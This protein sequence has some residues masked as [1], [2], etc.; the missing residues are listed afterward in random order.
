MRGK[1]PYVR[2]PGFVAEERAVGADHPDRMRDEQRQRRR[3][4]SAR[5]LADAEVLGEEQVAD[6][7]ERV[8]TGLGH[9][10]GHGP[11]LPAEVLRATEG[12]EPNV[13]P[14]RLARVGGASRRELGPDPVACRPV[15]ETRLERAGSAG[16]DPLRELDQEPRRG[17]LGRVGVEGD[18]EALGARVIDQR[19]HRLG[20][21]G[22][23]LAMVEVGDVGRA[24]ARRPISIASRNGSR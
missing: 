5:H 15:R 23:R 6:D 10:V 16:L 9:D 14:A 1:L 8:V 12:T 18:V 24:P 20:R 21:A 3:R 22:V 13:G 11:A 17:P 7:V 2:G 4:R 19:E